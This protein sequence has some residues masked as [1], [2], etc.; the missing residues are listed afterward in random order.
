MKTICCILMTCVFSFTAA[1][2]QTGPDKFHEP[3]EDPTTALVLDTFQGNRLNF[4]EL[5]REPRVAGIINR[6]IDGLRPDSR[7]A[8]RKAEA[9]RRGYKW[10]S[11][12]VGRPGNSVR[13]ADF[14]L[15][16]A[17][18][19]SDELIALDL[20]NTT[21]SS[22]NL[23]DAQVFIRRIKEKTGRYPLLYGTSQVRDAILALPDAQRSEFVNTPLWYARYCQEISCYFPTSIW[24]SYTLWQFASEINCPSKVTTK[25]S[26]RTNACPLNKCPLQ[27]PVP[28]T[29]FDMD[30]NVFYGT[31][32]EL[33]SKWPFT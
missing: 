20:E 30:V 33:K 5:A 23:D 1:F 6:A 17:Q 24:P 16:L 21:S 10:G 9:K 19:E 7:Y 32:E 31:V 27:R 2:G 14:Y 29:N 22:M 11:F 12:H 3:W 13:Q 18:P 8:E 28:G 25:R 15:E 26:C 4:N